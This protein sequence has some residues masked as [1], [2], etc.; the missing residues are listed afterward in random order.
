MESRNFFL[1]S[2]RIDLNGNKISVGNEISMALK[3]SSRLSSYSALENYIRL[4]FFHQTS[5][6]QTRP[7]H[8]KE[9]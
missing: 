2:T 6:N 7:D 5:R 4:K 8:T 3:F 1:D 9:K